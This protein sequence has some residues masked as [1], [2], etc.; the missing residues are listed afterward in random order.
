MEYKRKERTFQWENKSKV[1]E[2]AL[3]RTKLAP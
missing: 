3:L 2:T 1:S